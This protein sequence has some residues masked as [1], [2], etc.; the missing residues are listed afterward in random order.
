MKIALPGGYQEAARM[1]DCFEEPGGQ[2]VI[3]GHEVFSTSCFTIVL[4]S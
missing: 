3:C 2:Q 1:I 4:A